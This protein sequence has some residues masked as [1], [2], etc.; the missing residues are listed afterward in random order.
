LIKQISDALGLNALIIE[1]PG[2]GIYKGKPSSKQICKDALIA[3]DYLVNEVSF[4][5]EDIFIIGRSIGTGPATF[6]ANKR[7][8]GML[9]LISAFLSIKKLAKFY[10]GKFASFFTPEY[11]NNEKMIK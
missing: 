7:Q 8:P 6:C 9:I 2:Y 11:F 4:R 5:P 3:F 1:F 10:G